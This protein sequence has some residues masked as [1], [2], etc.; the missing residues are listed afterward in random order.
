MLTVW[1]YEGCWIFL[2]L[3]KVLRKERVDEESRTFTEER[4]SQLITVIADFFWWHIKG[5]VGVDSLGRKKA[6]VIKT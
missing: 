1:F 6:I 4:R 3:L 2:V 5:D